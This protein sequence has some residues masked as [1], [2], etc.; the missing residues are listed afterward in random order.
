[1][2]QYIGLEYSVQLPNR[3][4]PPPNAPLQPRSP[5]RSGQWFG[6]LRIHGAF[7]DKTRQKDYVPFECTACGAGAEGGWHMQLQNVLIGIGC[8]CCESIAS[9][10]DMVAGAVHLAGY[11]LKARASPSGRADVGSVRYRLISPDGTESDEMIR[12]SICAGIREGRIPGE[13]SIEAQQSVNA[14]MDLF[15]ATFPSATIRFEAWRLPNTTSPGPF[16]RVSTG[17]RRMRDQVTGVQRAQGIRALIRQEQQDNADHKSWSA[18]AAE[19]GAIIEGYTHALGSQVRIRYLSR[20]GFPREE[21]LQRAKESSWGHT[22]FK[23]GEKLCQ[24]VMLSLFPRSDWLWNQRCSFLK[25]DGRNLELDGYCENLALAF[26]HQGAQHHSWS[27]AFHPSVEDFNDLVARDTFKVERC[28]TLGIRLVVVDAMDLDAR[29]YLGSIRAR[30]REM[31]VPFEERATVEQVHA[32]WQQICANP[33]QRLQDA[34]IEGLGAH[35]LLTPPIAEV[36]A[37]ALIRYRCGTCGEQNEAVAK[38]FADSG[39]RTY[40]PCCKGRRS[41]DLRR[42]R[43][44]ASLRE[45][46]PPKI[47][48]RIESAPGERLSLVCDQGHRES[49]STLD[50]IMSRHDGVTYNCPHCQTLALGFADS[51]KVNRL[52]AATLKQYSPAFEEHIRL[53]GLT[54]TAPIA[55]VERSSALVAKVVCA[56]GHEFS[57]AMS[58]LAQL[59]RSK[60]LGDR[61]IAPTVCPTCC[62]PGGPYRTRDSTVFHRL[63]V[64]RTR[65]PNASFVSGFDPT[66]W[67]KERYTCGNSHPLSRIQHAGIWVSYRTLASKKVAGWE[68]FCY[69]CAE[70]RGVRM[71]SFD[72]NI[73]MVRGRMLVIAEAIA[74]RLRTRIVHIPTATLASGQIAVEEFIST[75][76]TLICFDCGTEGHSSEVKTVDAYF[77]RAGNKPGYCRDCLARAGVKTV[78]E[79][80]RS[81]PDLA[82]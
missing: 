7:E 57:T 77:A 71:P 78:N 16:F 6:E 67:S 15:T 82:S 40:C 32:L 14:L 44:L 23:K 47:F 62:Y 10:Q 17:T 74:K 55:Y 61:N 31:G 64:L 42:Q 45:T 52:R 13:T 11:K 50:A 18:I 58:D 80:L 73:A 37:A 79:L 27:I 22:R 29:I 48:K 19:H 24:A 1:M 59:L 60:Y 35:E 51:D 9:V 56:Q 72:K 20:S 65:H 36:T 4:M 70:E 28:R 8:P 68:S 33:L 75:T 76:K 69:E 3:S 21:T 41:G 46:L 49:V 66:G 25:F 30:L 5:H 63:A 2:T 34:V 43:L 12:S 54:R 26:E 81:A 38:G 39:P 53:A